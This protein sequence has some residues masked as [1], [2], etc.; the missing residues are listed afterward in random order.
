MNLKT[1]CQEVCSVAKSVGKYIQNERKTIDIDVETKSLNS[2]LTHVDKEAERRIVEQLTQLIPEA[3]FVAEEGTSDRKGE[4]FNWIIDP[5]D[6]TT[7]FI[8]S[9]PCFSVSIA[10]MRDKKLVLGVVYEINFDE[11]FYAWENSL[12]YLNESVISVSQKDK[13]S[14]SLNATGF[15]Y[16]DYGKLEPYLD[17][18]RF[19]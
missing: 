16:Y 2:F 10:L 1:L 4:K 11:C 15:P 13:L 9:I 19:F 5:L 6:G 8:H 18:F 14:D 12:A 7:N 3:G 17:F